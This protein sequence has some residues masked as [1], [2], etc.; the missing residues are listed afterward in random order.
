LMKFKP[1]FLRST[2]IATKDDQQKFSNIAL[3][4]GYAI[5]EKDSSR[6]NGK[7]DFRSL[8]FGWGNI[9]EFTFRA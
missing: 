8:L 4:N 1:R 6:N 3:W 2:E 9:A 7:S 5:I